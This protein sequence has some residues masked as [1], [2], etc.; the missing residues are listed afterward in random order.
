MKSLTVK[1]CPRYFYD[2]Y[3]ERVLLLNDTLKV[4]KVY[5]TPFIDNLK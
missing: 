1:I 2:T 3:I 4:A 5:I